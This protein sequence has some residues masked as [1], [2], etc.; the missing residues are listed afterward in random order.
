MSAVATHYTKLQ[1]VAA[2]SAVAAAAVLT[3]AAV[4]A[5]KPDFMP[6]T[7]VTDMIAAGPIQ[8]ATDVPFWWLDDNS[9]S[10]SQLLAFGPLAPTA[11]TILSFQPL[12][13]LPGFIQPL[14]GWFNGINIGICVAGLGVSVGPYGTVSVKS[15]AC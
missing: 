7:P 8:L 1:M 12:S 10:P 5:A 13:L 3:P 9:P 4:A 2:A 6:V 14:F 11:T 15:G